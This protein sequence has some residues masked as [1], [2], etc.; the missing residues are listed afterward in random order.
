MV[1]DLCHVKF[2]TASRQKKAQKYNKVSTLSYFGSGE[3][4]AK[5]RKHENTTK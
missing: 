4:Q 3:R 2:C 1:P 5:S